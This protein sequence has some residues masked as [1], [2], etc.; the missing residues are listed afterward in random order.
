M[1]HRSII[2][3]V[4]VS[5]TLAAVPTASAQDLRSPDARD[6]A[7]VPTSAGFDLRS[8][9]AR[10]LAARTAMDRRGTNAAD[11]WSSAD[12]R[13]YSDTLVAPEESPVTAPAV[14]SEPDAFDVRDAFIGALAALALAGAGVALTGFRRRRIVGAIGG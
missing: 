5:A 13:V 2:T 12:G 6:Q 1:R 9:D 4:L 7:S 8:P 10:E 14:V 3:A 11:F